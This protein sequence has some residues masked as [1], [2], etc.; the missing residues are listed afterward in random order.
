VTP[1]IQFDA[2]AERVAAAARDARSVNRVMYALS[3]AGN[4]SVVWHAINAADAL[5][6]GADGRRRAL[7]RS[8]VLVGEQ[9]LVNLG[10]KQ[11][12]RRVRP[13][14]VK[15]HPHALRTPR[16]SSFPSG[17]AS[18]GAC[19]AVLLTRDHGAGP[20]WWSMAAVISWSRVHVG[21]H[22]ASDVVGGAVVGAA[23]G[24]AASR[25]WPTPPRT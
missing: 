22:H 25:L 14:V 24:R 16:T 15:A 1:L 10:V 21:A 12:F 19:A 18:A 20:V 13:A 4:H 8:A 17:H 2:A 6:G 3:E 23:L 7:R 5:I 9:A 11:L